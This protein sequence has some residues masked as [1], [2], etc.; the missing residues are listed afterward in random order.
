MNVVKPAQP[1]LYCRPNTTAEKIRLL[2]CKH[3]SQ[4][5]GFQQHWRHKALPFLCRGT[6]RHRNQHCLATQQRKIAFRELLHMILQVWAVKN[7]YTPCLHCQKHG[8]PEQHRRIGTGRGP[9][10]TQRKSQWQSWKFCHWGFQVSGTFSPGSQTLSFTGG[11][12]WD[13]ETAHRSLHH[14]YLVWHSAG[15]KMRSSQIRYFARFLG[16]IGYI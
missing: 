2:P 7:T 1:S 5:E 6:T 3:S 8:D 14:R 11:R 12:L 4:Q 13:V 15:V 9:K 16:C 10:N